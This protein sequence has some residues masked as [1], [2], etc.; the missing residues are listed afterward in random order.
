[1]EAPVFYLRD[2]V[3]ATT[4]S[5]HNLLWNSLPWIRGDVPRR[6]CWLN[7]TG[8]VYTYG[9]EPFA[10]TY[11]PHDLDI[12]SNNPGIRLISEIMGTLNYLTVANYNCCFVNGYETGKDHL[13]W[14]SDDSP[15]MDNK[16]PISVISFGEEREIWFRH[17]TWIP[18][19]GGYQV[20]DSE[21]LL[22][23]DGSLLIMKEHMQQEW[24]HR[25]P[26][27]S[28][29]ESGSRVSLTFRRVN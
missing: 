16:H 17:R 3:K 20:V 9:T 7:T 28:K 2:F 27:S 4:W 29:H 26:K 22:L 1:M 23:E 13:G 18:D 19:P 24:Q 5:H 15:E 21:K 11:E 14:H 10:R 8:D 25:I 12:G 6:E